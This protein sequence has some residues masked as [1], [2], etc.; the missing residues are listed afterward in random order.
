MSRR[1]SPRGGPEDLPV[2][3]TETADE[4][5]RKDY[6]VCP[7]PLLARPSRMVW[8]RGLRKLSSFERLAVR[9]VPHSHSGR[10]LRGTAQSPLFPAQPLLLRYANMVLAAARSLE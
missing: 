5:R 6:V 10:V 7:P 3:P 9:H 1:T 8:R 2:P 4:T